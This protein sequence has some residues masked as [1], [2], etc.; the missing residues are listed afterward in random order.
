MKQFNA[1]GVCIPLVHSIRFGDKLLYEGTLLGK[2]VVRTAAGG[3]DKHNTH[4]DAG[5]P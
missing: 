2:S 4:M 5:G 3:D 1:T